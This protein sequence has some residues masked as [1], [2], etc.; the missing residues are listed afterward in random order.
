MA[1]ANAIPGAHEGLSFPAN[2]AFGRRPVRALLTLTCNMLLRVELL[3]G[4]DDMKQEKV[5]IDVINEV[6]PHEQQLQSSLLRLNSRIPVIAALKLV[7]QHME[8]N[9]FK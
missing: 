5:F 8:A 9:N 6:A 1:I 2:A 3:R 7:L 4:L